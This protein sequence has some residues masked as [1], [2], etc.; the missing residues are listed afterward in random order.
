MK[1]EVKFE[2]RSETYIRTLSEERKIWQG[3][4]VSTEFYS[5]SLVK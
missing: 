4:R 5:G 1:S 2:H 3:V